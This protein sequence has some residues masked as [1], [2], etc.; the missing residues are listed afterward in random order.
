MATRIG[1]RS[2]RLFVWVALIALGVSACTLAQKDGLE[3]ADAVSNE[4]GGV[5]AATAPAPG[6]ASGESEPPIGAPADLEDSRRSLVGDGG[7]EAIVFQVSDLG[8][9]IIFTADL[10][11][12]VQDVAAAGDEATRIISGFGGFLYGQ[13]TTASPQPQTVLVF[14]VFPEDFADALERL[15]SIGDL[16]DQNVTADDVTERVVDLRSRINTAEASVERLRGFLDEATDI[17]TIAELENQLLERETQLETLRGQLRTLEDQVALATITLTLTEAATRPGVRIDVSAYPGHDDSGA[18]CPGSTGL[19]V[20]KGGAV[21]VCFEIINVGD[22]DLTGLTLRDRLLDVELDDLI[23]VFG[24]PK[25]TIVPGQSIVVAAEVAADR[26]VRTQ[27][28]VTAIPVDEEGTEITGRSVS[29]TASMLIEAA[30]PGGVPTFSEGLE[31]SFDLL[32]NVG[33]ILVLAAGALVPFLPVLVGAWALWR[34]FARRSKP[35]QG[36]AEVAAAPQAEA[37]AGTS[38]E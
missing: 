9:D 10:T 37:A 19:T 35:G 36:A 26:T 21:T 27:T 30:D 6:G 17:E 8:R 24:D 20:D 33:A 12:A 13:R 18:S 16:R 1:T 22:T 34:W 15:G 4:Q 31:A 38:P 23:F 5:Q 25:E 14:K 2:K 29:N 28:T 11:V 7:T 3:L 32:R